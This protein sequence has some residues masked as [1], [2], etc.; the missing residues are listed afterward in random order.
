[1]LEP[2]DKISVLRSDFTSA[3]HN[4]SVVT[5]TKERVL[6][7]DHQSVRYGAGMHGEVVALPHEGLT[8]CRGWDQES[9]EALV[10]AWR[11]VQSAT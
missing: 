5:V 2:G 4:A 6:A 7:V 3:M 11:L 8:W 10:A 9:I 1:M